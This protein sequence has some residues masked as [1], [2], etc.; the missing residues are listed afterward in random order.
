[1]G[2]KRTKRKIYGWTKLIFGLFLT[3]MVFLLVLLA[4]VP[5]GPL[6]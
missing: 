1:V 6:I 2:G 5:T 4:I 3:A